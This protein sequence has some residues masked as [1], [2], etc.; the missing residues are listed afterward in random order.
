M[1]SVLDHT[2]ELAEERISEHKDKSI[3]IFQS[4]EQ[5]EQNMRKKMN[6]FRE[7]CETPLLCQYIHSRNPEKREERC[8]K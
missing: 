1:K 2:C 7:N 8:R 4:E 6:R 3:E 5:N